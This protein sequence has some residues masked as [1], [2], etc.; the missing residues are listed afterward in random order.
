MG[1]TAPPGM[2]FLAADWSRGVSLAC[3]AGLPLMRHVRLDDGGVVLWSGAVRIGTYR[4]KICMA[5]TTPPRPRGMYGTRSRAVEVADIMGTTAPP[6]MDF[7]AAD[8]SRGVS[9]AC[10][11][12][13]PNRRLVRLDDGGI[14]L[15]SGAVRIGTYRPKIR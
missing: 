14:A 13:L 12:G 10:A 15:W 4:P 2:D 3:A 7:L 6:G 8:W 1:T 5:N 11:A 9:L